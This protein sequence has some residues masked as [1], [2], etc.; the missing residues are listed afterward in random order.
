M[1]SWPEKININ[2]NIK[3]NVIKQGK[4]KEPGAH[5]RSAIMNT[6]CNVY[7]FNLLKAI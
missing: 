2:I 3:N 1:F 6:Y 7:S 4:V 5:K